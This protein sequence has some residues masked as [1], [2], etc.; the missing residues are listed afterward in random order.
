MWNERSSAA[1]ACPDPWGL[2]L[3]GRACR[4]RTHSSSAQRENH[5]GRRCWR[6]TLGKPR[7]LR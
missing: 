1:P 7:D 2:P 5:C 6:K 4:V 3:S